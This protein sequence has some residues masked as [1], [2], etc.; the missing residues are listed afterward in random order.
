[1]ETNDLHLAWGMGLRPFTLKTSIQHVPQV[2]EGPEPLASTTSY[3][4]PLC[5]LN[6]C[7]TALATEPPRDVLF[8]GHVL[9]FL[10]WPG[11]FQ[12]FWVCPEPHGD[13]QDPEE[14]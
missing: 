13:G 7:P 14:T 8:K 9:H 11:L 2:G 10:P 4:K 5:T 12:W 3:A 1:M 6:G